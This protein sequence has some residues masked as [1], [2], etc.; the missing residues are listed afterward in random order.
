LTSSRWGIT[1]ADFILDSQASSGD[2]TVTAEMGSERSSHTVEVKPYTLPRFEIDYQSDKSFY[3]PGETARISVAAQYFFGKPVAGGQVRITGFVTDIGRQPIFE[4]QEGKTDSEGF[5]HFDFPLPETLVAQLENNTAQVDLEIT[6]IDTANHAETVSESI[7]VAGQALLVEAVPESGSLR[8]DVENIIYL[9]SSYPNGQAAVTTMTVQITGT[10][11]QTVQT[12]AYGLAKVTMTPPRNRP[13]QLTVQAIDDQGQEATQRLDL[14]T[15]TGAMAILLRP[16]KTA[17]QIGETMQIDALVSG[18][19]ATVYL[20]V[21]KGGQTFAMAALPVQNGLAAASIDI[22][23]SLLGT[24]EL[25]AYVITNRGQIVRDRR[26]VLVNPAPGQIDVQADAEV[27]RPGDTAIL[28]VTASRAEAP[29]AGVLGISIVDES[30]FAVG[31]QDPGFARTY[32]LLERELLEPRY[33]IHDFSPL[34]GEDSPYDREFESVRI[35]QQQNFNDMPLEEARQ[36]ALAGALAQELARDDVNAGQQALHEAH[37]AQANPDPASN[38]APW[39]GVAGL[40]LLTPLVGLICY[41][42]RKHL[43]NL[44]LLLLLVSGL[45]SFIVS[46]SPAESSAPQ[47]VQQDFAAAEAPA[48]EEAMAEPLYQARTEAESSPADEAQAQPPR[49]RQFFPETLFWLPEL[50]TDEN[51][52]AQIEVPIADS[53]TTWRVSVLASDA[54]GNLGSTQ[55]G[56]RVFQDFF[57][58]PD[59]PR[60]LTQNDELAVPVSIFNYLDEPQKIQLEVAPAAWFEFVEAPELTFQI[61]ANEVAATYIPIRVTG[62]GLG[63]FK[64]TATGDHMSDAVLRQVEILPHGKPLAE[65]ENGKLAGDVSHQITLPETIVP[66]TA[67]ITVKVFPSVVSQVVEGLEGLLQQPYGCFEQTSSTTYPNVLVLDY[68]KTTGQIDPSIQLQAEQYI[69]LGY[70][71]LLTFEV[72]DYPGGFSLFGDPPP[73]TMLTAYGLMEFSDMSQVSYVDPALLERTAHFLFSQQ[74]SDGSWGAEGM[75][76]ESGWER[77]GQANLPVTAYIT[78]A[79]AEAGYAETGQVQTAVQ[80]IRHHATSDMD[81]YALAIVINALVAVDPEDEMARDLLDGTLAQAEGDENGLIYWRSDLPTY[82]GG[83]DQVA[84]LETTAMLAIALLRSGYRPDMVQPALD[85]LVS[86]R[87]SYGTFYTTQSTILALKALLLG[88]KQG[89][90]GGEATVTLTLND[91]HTKTLVVNA[92]N[93]DVVQQVSFDDLSPGQTYSLSMAVDGERTPH[94]QIVTDYYLPWESVIEEPTAQPAM[95]VDV[96]YDRT[97]LAVNDTVLV[98]AEVELLA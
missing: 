89:D 94:Y 68:L 18:Q 55:T 26:L 36:V 49:L 69:N 97:E 87:D 17:Y 19:A 88:V 50:E 1:A 63:D 31:A 16:E 56:L 9:Q 62:F 95:Q 65:V 22:D 40:L 51:G 44:L 5:Y 48:A 75:T 12:D 25:H 2:Y 15:S 66:G 29:M 81:P 11:P 71:R 91:G 59:L 96:T 77:L 6:V 80:Y 46:C 58:E 67:Q 28:N 33:E 4:L 32:F 30:V 93:A 41:D 10:D 90:E 3:L 52:Q 24:L 83:Q 34:G 53:I 60:F 61:G 45:G 27:Y 86:Q 38:D 20:D 21:V 35:A 13:V 57:V 79:L 72:S 70:Q 73:W 8:P 64:I 92:E 98:T 54:A 42:E 43:R 47:A 39:G 14:D 78:W 84:S 85:F 7:T 23:G 82:M 37:L 74:R 76:V